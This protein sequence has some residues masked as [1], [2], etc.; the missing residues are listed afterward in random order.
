MSQNLGWRQ[1]E[2]EFS[3]YVEDRD[4][5]IVCDV[6]EPTPPPGVTIEERMFLHRLRAQML[7][8]APELLAAA[9][10]AWA[11]ILQ[12]NDPVAI[13]VRNQLAD[14]IRKARSVTPRKE[15]QSEVPVREI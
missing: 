14:A 11:I 10:S 12:L 1:A 9:N 15:G 7:A 13:R 5:Q 6:R 3:I 4:G 2:D 8:A